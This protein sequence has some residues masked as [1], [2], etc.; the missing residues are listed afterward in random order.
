MKINFASPTGNSDQ[1]N[2][3]DD[4]LFGKREEYVKGTFENFPM[5]I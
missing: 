2:I 5:I 1:T 3:I 4:R